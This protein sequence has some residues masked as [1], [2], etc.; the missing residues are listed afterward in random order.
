MLRK[1]VFNLVLYKPHNAI[2]LI[3]SVRS[4][5]LQSATESRLSFISSFTIINIMYPTNAGKV[6]FH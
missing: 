6:V 5:E 1:I 3:D 2:R 4:L